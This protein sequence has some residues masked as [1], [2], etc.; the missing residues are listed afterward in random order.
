MSKLSFLVTAAASLLLSLPACAQTADPDAGKLPPDP[1]KAVVASTCTACHE[2]ARIVYGNYDAEGWHNVVS[3]MMNAGAP[4]TPD[5][6]APVT[7]YLIK[8]FPE[9]PFP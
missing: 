9:K 6:V 4:L 1:E 5:Q 7:A 8:S 2:L 3:M